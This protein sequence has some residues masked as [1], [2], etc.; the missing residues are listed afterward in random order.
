[1]LPPILLSIKEAPRDYLMD[2][3]KVNIQPI[4]VL[5]GHFLFQ[6]LPRPI[7]LSIKEALRDYLMDFFKVN[8]QPIPVL[9]GHFLLYNNQSSS[10]RAFWLNFA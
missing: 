5:G 7:L 3:L 8:I 1:M 6:V 9:G 2:F 10:Y 4:P